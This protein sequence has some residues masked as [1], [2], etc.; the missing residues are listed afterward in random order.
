MLLYSFTFVVNP[1]LTFFFGIIWSTLDSLF[2]LAKPPSVLW[3]QPAIQH[4]TQQTSF[5]FMIPLS[6]QT[7][8]AAEHGV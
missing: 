7:R 3:S 2:S 5:S 1:L 4:M 6:S 8:K